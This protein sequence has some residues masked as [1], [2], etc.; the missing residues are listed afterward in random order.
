[1]VDR[2][3]MFHIC[4]LINVQNLVVVTHAVCVSVQVGPQNLEDAGGRGPTP[5]DGDV[6]APNRNSLLPSIC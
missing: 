1:V 5:W 4:S 2:V 3:K 6:A